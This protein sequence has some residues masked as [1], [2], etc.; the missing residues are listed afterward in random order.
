MRI[1][2]M[3]QKAGYPR[4]PMV[5]G[6]AVRGRWARTH[7]ALGALVH[8]LARPGGGGA[9]GAECARCTLVG[10]RG[11]G[12]ISARSSGG[13]SGGEHGKRGRFIVR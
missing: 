10:V 4:E 13:G 12:A 6:G 7:T 2:M 8:I 1:G 9:E 5:V 11:G 3:G